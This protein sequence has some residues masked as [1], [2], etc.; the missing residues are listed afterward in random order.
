VL[1]QHG[2]HENAKSLRRNS[3]GLSAGEHYS[4]CAETVISIATLA[5]YE[6]DFSNDF[7]ATARNFCE[8]MA[9]KKGIDEG[10]GAAVR[11]T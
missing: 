8:R 5:E 11:E 9:Q 2:P 7:W 10:S 3:N 1:T 6:S 4:S